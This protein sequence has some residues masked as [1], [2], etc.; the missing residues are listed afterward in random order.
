MKRRNLALLALASFTLLLGCSVIPVHL[1]KEV[2]RTLTFAQLREAPEAHI[3]KRVVLGGEVIDT[4][5]LKEGTQIE[6]LEKPLAFDD[7]PKETDES[8]GRFLAFY[9][10]FLDRAIYR[11]GRLVTVVGEVKGKRVQPLGEIDYTYPYIVIRFISLL[12]PV[13]RYPYPDYPYLYP[14]PW[15]YWYPYWPYWRYPY[16]LYPPYYYP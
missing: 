13:P 4:R 12:P 2:D 9:P 14:P 3:G 16:Y 6:V 15:S 1:R 7:T 8:G 5:N 11:A 10:G